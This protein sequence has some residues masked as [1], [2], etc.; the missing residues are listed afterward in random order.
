MAANIK[1]RLSK[2]ICTMKTYF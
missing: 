2:K 1:V